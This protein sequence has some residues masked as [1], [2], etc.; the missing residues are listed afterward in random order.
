MDR[1]TTI[2]MDRD[3]TIDMNRGTTIQAVSGMWEWKARFECCPIR[4]FM[5]I[6]YLLNLGSLT[7]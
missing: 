5:A 2:Y 1:D 4:V 6:M 7:L 3:T